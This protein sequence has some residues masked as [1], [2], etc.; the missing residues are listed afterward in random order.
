MA[1]HRFDV[2]KKLDDVRRTRVK[3]A[4]HDIYFGELQEFHR[5]SRRF[6]G[7]QCMRLTE[8]LLQLGESFLLVSN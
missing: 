5:V 8:Q 1:L 6:S 2:F 4:Y 7:E 3:G